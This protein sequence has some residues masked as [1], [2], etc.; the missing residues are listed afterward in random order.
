MHLA[1]SVGTPCAAIFSA[2]NKPGVWFPYGTRHKVVYHQVECYGCGLDLCERAK[3]KCISSITPEEFL[4][5][6][7]QVMSIGNCQLSCAALSSNANHI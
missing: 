7:D 4:D 5:A 6:C 3:K 2:R 1:A